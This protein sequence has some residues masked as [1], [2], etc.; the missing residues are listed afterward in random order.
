[1]LAVTGLE[2]RRYKGEYN[3]T[4]DHILSVVRNIIDRLF[5]IC[6]QTVIVAL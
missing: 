4:V 2:N 1:M 3:I 5:R 6:Y